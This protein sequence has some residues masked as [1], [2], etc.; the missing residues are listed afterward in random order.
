MLLHQLEELSPILALSRE[1]VLEFL[2]TTHSVADT[3]LDILHD[4]LADRD[5]SSLGRF[6]DR[7]VPLDVSAWPTFLLDATL[8]DLVV[9][10][11]GRLLNPPSEVDILQ[12]TG[13]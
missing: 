2:D 10:K 7:V 3:P 9:A 13:V 1:H 12:L 11:I 6:L 8:A 5:V 4:G